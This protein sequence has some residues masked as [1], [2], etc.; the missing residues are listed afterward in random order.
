MRK[1]IAIEGFWRI[2]KTS[3]CKELSRKIKKAKYIQEPD[4]LGMKKHPGNVEYWYLKKWKEKMELAK[5]YKEK[6]YTV[7]MERSFISTLAFNNALGKKITDPMKKLI[8]YH[9]KNTPDIIIILEA[10]LPFLKRIVFSKT[11]KKILKTRVLYKQRSFFRKYIECFRKSVAHFKVKHFYVQ[12][13]NDSSFYPLPGIV[14]ASLKKLKEKAP[15][16]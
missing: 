5:E 14:D 13:A 7:I 1:I 15:L 4:H 3:L 10:P 9:E 2:G 11:D 6:G 8:K 12:V 16:H